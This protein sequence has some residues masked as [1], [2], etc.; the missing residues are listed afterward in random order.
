MKTNI[1]FKKLSMAD[2]DINGNFEPITKEIE[3][4]LSE[5]LKN[6]KKTKGSTSNND[7]KVLVNV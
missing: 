6:R 5:F 7:N 2:L 3:Q 4:A 1:D